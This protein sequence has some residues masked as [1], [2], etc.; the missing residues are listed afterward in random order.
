VVEVARRLTSK[1][2]PI[3]ISVMNVGRWGIEQVQHAFWQVLPDRHISRVINREFSQKPFRSIPIY[4]YRY[5]YVLWDLSRKVCKRHVLKEL[6][7]IRYDYSYPDVMY[8][9]S[10][11]Y[12]RIFWKDDTTCSTWVPCV[13]PTTGWIPGFS[14]CSGQHAWHSCRAGCIVIS[15]NPQGFA[16][17]M[18]LIGLPKTDFSKKHK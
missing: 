3:S 11:E 6:V 5:K 2:T 10:C 8:Y 16:T 9:A 12:L 15:E 7:Q 18:V 13:L 14:A 4:I 17:R 1:I